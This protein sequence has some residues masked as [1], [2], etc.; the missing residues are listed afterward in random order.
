MSEQIKEGSYIKW[1][2]VNGAKHEGYV[3]EMDSNVA[4]VDCI[5]CKKVCIAD[6]C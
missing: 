4:Y 2:Q 3:K 6:N 5:N 1:E